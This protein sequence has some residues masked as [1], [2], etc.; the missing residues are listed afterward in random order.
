[1]IAPGE[2]AA[3]R[4]DPLQTT[5]AT[6]GRGCCLEPSQNF[7]FNLLWQPD[8]RSDLAGGSRGRYRAPLG[9]IEPKTTEEDRRGSR[10]IGRESS[11]NGDEY[12]DYQPL[13]CI[14]TEYQKT[15][16]VRFGFDKTTAS[17]FENC[18]FDGRGFDDLKKRM[19]IVTALQSAKMVTPAGNLLHERVAQCGRM[20]AGASL[21]KG[22]MLH[23]LAPRMCGHR[24]CPGCQRSKSA[25]AGMRLTVAVAQRKEKHPNRKVIFVT[26]TQVKI[27]GE[28]AIRSV[29][30]SKASWKSLRNRKWWKD[31]VAGGIRT[32]EVTR[33]DKGD[34]FGSHVARYSGFHSHIHAI[35]E[36]KDGIGVGEFR[37]M[38]R[39]VWPKCSPGATVMR[40]AVGLAE[41]GRVGQ[42]AKYCVKPLE[43]SYKKTSHLVE[44]LEALRGRRMLSAFGEWYT[45]KCIAKA[46]ESIDEEELASGVGLPSMR[47]SDRSVS[48][49]LRYGD[50]I[51]EF[52]HAID[53]CGVVE[54]VPVSDVARICK[55]YR[56]LLLRDRMEIGVG[57]GVDEYSAALSKRIERIVSE[58]NSSHEIFVDI[59]MPG[60]VVEHGGKS[61]RVLRREARKLGW[62]TGQEVARRVHASAK[63][64]DLSRRAFSAIVNNSGAKEAV[65]AYREM[66]GGR[67]MEEL[68]RRLSAI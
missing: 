44:L 8:S 36:L 25:I 38:L 57:R 41:D 56:G 15:V 3:T 18:G 39:D 51:F 35:V 62:A 11:S 28:G 55:K 40:A 4:L 47:L 32:D 46:V 50:E 60:A 16:G 34:K 23:G 9:S 64:H 1:M 45:E 5:A 67:H 29:E 59:G 19:A 52:A 63:E 43:K 61:K 31:L 10:I 54:K 22:K 27:G 24:F 33:S 14:R 2:K 53:G 17:H 13:R 42:I 68:D 6:T 30:R 21:V 37:K 49:A 65:E 48:N 7:G 66:S 58:G 12:D 20:F 26:L